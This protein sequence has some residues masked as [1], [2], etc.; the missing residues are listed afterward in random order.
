[1]TSDDGLLTVDL[2]AGAVA[3]DFQ[4][5]ASARGQDALPPELAGVEVRSAF[6]ELLPAD[7]EFDIPAT[8]TRRVSFEDLDLA[9]TDGLP[10][11]ALALRTADDRWEW[12]ADQTLSQSDDFVVASGQTTRT[13]LVFAFGGRTFTTFRVSD[14]GPLQVGASLEM[15]AT[16]KFPAESVDPPS[17][18]PFEPIVASEVAAPGLGTTGPDG[19]TLS[20][21]FVCADAGATV[22]GVAYSVLGAENVLFDRLGLP[23]ASTTVTAAAP[24]TCIAPATPSAPA[25][26]IGRATQ[27]PT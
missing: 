18:G 21:P 9:Q 22:V 7:A 25:S 13:G 19:A 17:L 11:L 24:V 14:D 4:L 8:V 1:V 20:Q 3:D 5:T 12:L 10:V 2:P 23:P 26:T 27:R 15:T 6:Y 16:L